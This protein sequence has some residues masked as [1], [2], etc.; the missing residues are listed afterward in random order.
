MRFDKRSRLG[1]L[2]GHG[3]LIM[4]V[5]DDVGVRELACAILE[6]SNYRVIAVSG[7]SEALVCYA[8]LGLDITAVMV[9]M[10]M[11]AMDGPTTIRG[12]RAINPQIRIIAT[13]GLMEETYPA[14]PNVLARL[15][16]PYTAQKLLSTLL[17][18]IS[19]N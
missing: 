11:P 15:S 13:S 10:V 2:A 18:V 16:K 8:K 14:A 6:S 4:V 5:D 19:R 3:E 7:G 9:D 12:L 17:E 1:S